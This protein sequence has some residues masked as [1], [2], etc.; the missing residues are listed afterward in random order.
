MSI[1]D[2]KYADLEAEIAEAARETRAEPPPSP[3]A[4]SD[5]RRAETAL[6]VALTFFF[7]ATSLTIGIGL[8]FRIN[9]LLWPSTI[10][11]GVLILL[12]AWYIA[13]G[14]VRPT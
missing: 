6:A 11:L 14:K 1:R 2:S 7:I 10:F 12:F 3:K 5:E 8:L 9:M 4:R 13:L